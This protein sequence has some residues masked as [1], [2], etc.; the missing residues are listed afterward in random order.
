MKIDECKLLMHAMLLL[1]SEIDRD[2]LTIPEY[3]KV[4]LAKME[5]IR[6]NY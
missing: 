6:S 5:E 3:N 2:T 1:S 4:V